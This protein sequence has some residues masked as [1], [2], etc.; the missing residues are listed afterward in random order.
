MIQDA[1]RKFKD[2]GRKEQIVQPESCVLYPQL[3]PACILDSVSPKQS[4]FKASPGIE[5]VSCAE[6]HLLNDIRR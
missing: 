6:N 3:V 2:T 1:S 4:G 5:F